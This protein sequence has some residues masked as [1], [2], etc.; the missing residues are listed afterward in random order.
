MLGMELIEELV[1]TAAVSWRVKGPRPGVSLVLIAD[2]ESGKTSITE[3]AG[4]KRVVRVTVTTGI[5]FVRELDRNKN[6]R[7]LIINDLSVLKGLN[8]R[9]A[10]MLIQIM[11]GFTEEGI[12]ALA[13]PRGKKID[14]RGRRGVLIACITTDSFKSSKRDWFSYGFLSRSIPF[15]YS[16]SNELCVKIKNG[17]DH[18]DPVTLARPH[19]VTEGAGTA[20]EVSDKMGTLVRKIADRRAKVLEEKGI[21]LLYNYRQLVRSHAL[22]RNRTTVIK[23]DIR[24]LYRVDQY[25]NYSTPLELGSEMDY[26]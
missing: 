21:R 22:L 18:D 12:H 3:A 19:P 15:C 14:L 11:N 7:I 5:G 1:Q 24:F 16:Y 4:A 9:A 17:I 23:E 10:Y 13:M 25:V 8:S 2:P 26:I 20:I 6:A